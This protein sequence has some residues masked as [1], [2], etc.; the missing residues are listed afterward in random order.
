V[1]GIIL[2]GGTG[3]RLDPLTRAVNKHLLPLGDKP[4]ICHAVERMAELGIRDLVVVCD[5]VSRYAFSRLFAD[6]R[7]MDWASGI[8]SAFD[9]VE[10]VV[11][12]DPD[13]IV[14]A[15]RAVRDKTIYS[16]LSGPV[17]VLLGDNL[18]LTSLGPVLDHFERPWSFTGAHATLVSAT[19][20][21]QLRT[22][23]V[24]EFGGDPLV[25]VRV[26]EKPQAPPSRLVVTGFYCFGESLWETI[27]RIAPSDRG[28]LE[29]TDL[30]NLYIKA[31]LLSC[32]LGTTR[33]LPPIWMDAGSSIDAYHKACDVARMKFTQDVKWRTV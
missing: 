25:P 33:N 12:S 15:L 7:K 11:Q 8:E 22:S 26:V 3:S 18:F 4:M 20:R 27:D 6:A 14:G 10:L 13:G 29:I 30:L 32:S 16:L 23:G 31:G 21:E 24:M 2:A 9:R 28:E 19:S 1:T 17:C 5:P